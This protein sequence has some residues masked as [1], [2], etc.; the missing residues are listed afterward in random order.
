[1]EIKG[2]STVKIEYK[3]I[4]IHFLRKFVIKYQPDFV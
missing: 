4:L 2:Y 1:M 3:T